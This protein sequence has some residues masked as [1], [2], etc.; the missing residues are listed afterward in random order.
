MLVL[1]TDKLEYVHYAIQL[2]KRTTAIIKQNIYFSIII[3]LIA[4][5]LVFPGWLTLWLAILSDTGAAVLVVL[6]AL[7]LLK[8]IKI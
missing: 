6:N 7:R 1:M 3:K 5:M 4:F 2:S 8:G